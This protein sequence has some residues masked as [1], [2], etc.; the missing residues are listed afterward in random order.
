MR[1]EGA[2]RRPLP[3]VREANSN[4][5]VEV[6]P[7]SGKRV[8]GNGKEW[9]RLREWLSNEKRR[10]CVAFLS[11]PP[12]CGKNF[13]V[14]AEAERRGISVCETNATEKMGEEEV[15][16]VIRSARSLP[17]GGRTIFVFDGVEEMEEAGLSLLLSHAG[18]GEGKLQ[19]IICLANDAPTPRLRKLREACLDVR[20]RSVEEEEMRK[21]AEKRVGK[22]EARDAASRAG[23]DMR[24]LNIL[25]EGFESKLDK[26]SL[27]PSRVLDSVFYGEKAEVR[28]DHIKDN[29]DRILENFLPSAS[30]SETSIHALADKAESASLAC[31]LSSSFHL[32][33]DY[34]VSLLSSLSVDPPPP[35]G[36]RKV[37]NLGLP[38]WK[39]MSF[40]GKEKNRGPEIKI[41]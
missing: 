39:K 13:G 26:I 41:G 18:K 12:G 31:C 32:P 22:E 2:R 38:L 17:V 35:R 14:E 6:A 1:W 19:P 27:H 3:E 37:Y 24:Q 20:L 25:L 16:Q 29:A 11:G 15:R 23:G 36:K 4:V 21:W 8:I 9:Q 10:P 34:S 40:N 33:S 7:S 5:R 30:V 28:D